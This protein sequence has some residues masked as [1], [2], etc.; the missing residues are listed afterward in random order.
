[1][2]T[3]KAIHSSIV[4]IARFEH[5]VSKGSPGTRTPNQLVKSQW[6]YRLS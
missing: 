2:K 5:F 6:L 4:A 1:M 3:C